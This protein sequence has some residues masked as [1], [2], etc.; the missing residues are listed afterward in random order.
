MGDNKEMEK[1]MNKLGSRIDRLE[2]NVKK[3]ADQ[4]FQI[5]KASMD[6]MNTLINKF[7]NNAEK[8]GDK[9]QSD[10]KGHEKD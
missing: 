6:N 10:K 8:D 2:L 7:E 5:L 9:E 1:K 3:I 4:N